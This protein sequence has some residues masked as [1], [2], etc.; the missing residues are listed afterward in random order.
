[1][2]RCKHCLLPQKVPGSDLDSTGVCAP[3]RAPRADALGEEESRKRRESDLER[4]LTSV[5]GSGAY[6]AIVC[7]SGGKDS[8][9]LLH[10][11]K[12]EYG[13]RVLAFTTDVNIPEVAWASMR[14]AVEKLKVDHV[15]VRPPPDFYRRLFRH[16]LMNQEARGAVYSVSH[17]Y[18]PLFEGDALTVAVE[19]NIPLV[20]AG[21]SP[22]QPE[23][24]RMVYEFPHAFIARTDWTPPGLR[25]AKIF[26]EEE[27]ARFWNPT[28]K[29]PE[30]TAFP[31]YL[32]P[33]HAWKYD[34]AEVM[35]RVVELGLVKRAT[36]ASPIVSN[37]PINWLMMFSDLMN[38]GYNPYAP[39]F[40]A[41]IRKGEASAAYWRVL[42]PLVDLMIKQRAL[43]GRHVTSHLRWLD[44][45][46]SDLRV[47]L[48]EGSYD[49]VVTG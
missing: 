48:P 9:F 40:A 12:V 43:L 7:L 33:F 44:L 8:L 30:G 21:Y 16:V 20:L 46:P 10:R 23:P 3:C 24:E 13:L 11:I 1:M 27:L 26:S 32:A 42:G 41:L 14:R 25:Y 49:P 47:T 15:V 28:K 39:E 35:K 18:A 37:Y 38:F 34:Q 45:T 17:V 5:R 4:T 19:K 6:D 31:R 36:H 22:G 29:F 2:R